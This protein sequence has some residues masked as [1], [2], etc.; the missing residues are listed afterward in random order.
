MHFFLLIAS[1]SSVLLS[2][3]QIFSIVAYNSDLLAYKLTVQ[4]M[5]SLAQF[6]Q[7]FT[8]LNQNSNRFL[9]LHC[10]SEDIFEISE[11]NSIGLASE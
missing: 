6:G 1:I 10:K 9:A 8:T 4:Y 7:L 11:K 5:Y 3:V 2:N